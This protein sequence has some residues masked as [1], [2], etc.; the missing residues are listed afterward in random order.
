MKDRRTKFFTLP[1]WIFLLLPALLFGQKFSLIVFPDTQDEIESNPQ[2]FYDQCDWIAANADSLNTPMV[3]HVG[4]LVNF[5]NFDHFEMASKG[6]DVLDRNH[7]PY[8]I[9][10]GNH[11]GE[12][13][14]VH[15]RKLVKEGNVNQLLRRTSKFNSYFP[16]SR[17][18]AQRGRYEEG[19]SDNAYYTFKVE[20]TNWLVVTLEFSPRRDMINWAGEI[21]EEYDEYN[22]IIVTHYYLTRDGEIGEDV[23]FAGNNSPRVIKDNLVD[24][25][26]NI[27]FV[28]SGH[29][30]TSAY[31]VDEGKEGNKVYSI[32]QDY[33]KEDF[34]G[35]YLRILSFDIEKKS[36]DA[37]MYSPYYNKMKDDY[38]KFSLEGIEFLEPK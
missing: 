30:G 35:G 27:K 5:N 7:I 23:N 37:K 28:L 33:Q 36:L 12:S 22:V 26:P 38:S 16:V 4:D 19:K 9:A 3:L 11:D 21:I 1:I 15:H 13:V 24:I 14:G 6:F 17:F 34:G 29:T 25:Y 8:A 32:L 20:N 31:R 18:T 10:L 2:M